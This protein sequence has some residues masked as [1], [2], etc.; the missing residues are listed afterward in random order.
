M[1]KENQ[2]SP[3]VLICDCSSREHQI[4]IERDIED[5]LIYCHIHLAKHG[6]LKRLKYGLKYVF[7]YKC[8]YGNWEEFIL[9]PEHIY[10]LI[11]LSDIELNK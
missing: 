10:N 2:Q 6:F 8:K 3:Y 9:K 11:E 4:I 7:G 1:S 5:N